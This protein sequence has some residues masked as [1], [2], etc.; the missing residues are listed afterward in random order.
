MAQDLGADPHLARMD[1]KLDEENE[2]DETM[3][4]IKRLRSTIQVTSVLREQL[5]SIL[6]FLHG[7]EKYRAAFEIIASHVSAAGSQDDGDDEWEE[8]YLHMFA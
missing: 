2:E 8:K 3:G 7:P 6:P 4:Q 5:D 1:A